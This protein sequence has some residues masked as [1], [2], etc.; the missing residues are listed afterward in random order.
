[1]NWQVQADKPLFPDLVWD[2]P[3]TKSQQPR[4][5]LVGGRGQSLAAPL[6]LHRQLQGKSRLKIAVP[7]I[8][9]KKLP[10]APV[11]VVFC[12]SNQ[13]G[14]LA[15]RGLDQ[16]LVLAEAADA[17]IVGGSIGANN[18]TQQLVDQLIERID[19]P[20]II[21]DEA[22][23]GW[24]ERRLTKPQQIIVPDTVGFSQLL[25][26]WRLTPKPLSSLNRTQLMDLLAAPELKNLNLVVDM[27]GT[28][29]VKIASNM[30]YNM[31]A[32]R[33]RGDAGAIELAGRVGWFA[34]QTPKNLFAAATTASYR[35]S[36][37]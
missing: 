7:D 10:Q 30:C 36:G 5:L 18:E 3:Q 35:A 19:Q 34:G 26:H 37:D 22:L 14:S 8:W 21:T 25:Q 12:P 13:S 6:A 11:E 23:R 15:G 29:W 24:P 4:L 17:V 31:P 28:T 27:A 20:T 33:S 32:N 16:L 2:Q 1:M 9:Q